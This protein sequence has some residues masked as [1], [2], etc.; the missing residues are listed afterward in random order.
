MAGASSS[1]RRE[2][3]A[4]QLLTL[5]LVLSSIG[6]CTSVPLVYVGYAVTGVGAVL[7]YPRLAPFLVGSGWAV[8]LSLWMI[9]CGW[10]SPYA[11]N[12]IPPAWAY[13][14]PSLSLWALAA[15]HPR[16]I[17]KA[18]FGVAVSGVLA[19]GLALMQFT[20]GYRQDLAPFRL[21]NG[22]ERGVQA[23]GFY[24]HWIRY[25]NALA[26]V[27][28]WIV[29]WL[30]ALPRPAVWRWAG[31]GMV[32]AL[33]STCVAISGARG[34]ILALFAGAWILTTGMFRWRRVIVATVVLLGLLGSAVFF[35]WPAHGNRLT[36]ALAGHDGR[37]FIWRTSWEIFRVHPWLGI[38][39]FAY[40]ESATATV[41]QGLS[42]PGPEGPRMGNAHNSFLSLLVLYGI[43]G[44]MLWLGWITRVVTH[45]WQF[46]HRHPAA[47]PLA[48]ATLGV[49]LVGSLTEDLAAYAASRFQL[50]FGL[51][52]ALGC[53]ANSRAAD[54]EMKHGY[55]TRS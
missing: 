30:H 43:P 26:F 22:G 16:R 49:F 45:I 7:I 14:W 11:N 20:L 36:D 18:W 23:S 5:G 25:G 1:E 13:C 46:R 53:T 9:L 39:G 12:V 31:I 38:G 40:D 54:L 42:Q 44:L 6:I 47:W 37:T 55:S 32:G 3:W 33:G 50:F 15:S 24:S 41:A 34:A 29:A 4:D 8:A 19:G 52:L 17:M 28:L 21:G 27:T 10:V 2:W 51:A 35:L 48:L